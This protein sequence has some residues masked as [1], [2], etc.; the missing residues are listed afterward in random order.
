MWTTLKNLT[1]CLV[2][3]AALVITLT[4]SAAAQESDL[5]AVLR[6]SAPVQEKSA[7]CRQ[8]ARIATPDAVPTLAGLLG[9][10][11]LSH[12][13]RYA[14]EAIDHPSVD[15]ALRDAVGKVQG[16]PRLGVIGSLGVRRDPLA[17]PALAGLLA[18][19]DLDAAQAAARALGNIGTPEAARALERALPAAAGPQQLA[20]CEGWLRCAEALTRD[21]HETS[22]REI[23]DRLRA[24]H[25]APPQVRAAALRGAI[26]IRGTEGAALLADAIRSTDDV[27]A[28]AAMRSAME[29]PGP[30]ITAALVAALPDVAPA[31]QGLLMLALADR[32]EPQVLP[33][34]LEAAQRGDTP[35]RLVAIRA[36]RRVGDASCFPALMDAA[37]QGS[38]DVS[39]AALETLESLQ[40]QAI[41]DQLVAQL[42]DAEGN[43]RMVL[44]ELATRRRSAAAADAF[45]RATEDA[46]PAVRVAA[47]RGLGAVLDAPEVPRLIARLAVN[48]T[49]QEAAALDQALRDIALRASDREQIARQLA[50]ALPTV[51]APVQIRVLE[52]LAAIG[53]NAALETVAAAARSRDDAQRDAAFRVLGQW[54]SIDVAPVLLDLHNATGDERLKTRA[55]RAYIR[56]ARQFDM[57]AD[58]RAEMCRVALKTATRD[59][60]KRLVL[61]ILLRYPS[62]EMQAIALEAAEIPALKDE[63]LLVVMGLA[64]AGINRD[65][66][67][68]ALAQAG[69][70]PVQLEILHAQYGAGE[71][72]KDVTAAL[73]QYAKNY[74]II[75]LP[76]ASYNESLGGDPAP[77]IVKQLKIKYRIDGKEGE[78][79]LSENAMV[80]LPLPQ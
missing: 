25:D 36:L 55:I 3:A 6:S 53:G 61:E 46:A 45:W 54:S 11:R 28:A 35:L 79:V 72:T 24:L 77:G 27:L 17:V 69:Q 20:V 23:Y 51:D 57:P 43:E 60:D 29:V 39:S 33:T 47:W 1:R 42:A 10:E 37:A 44:I 14:L 13:A 4:A 8:L 71:Q 80:V 7:A 34:V 50:D 68:K 12:M 21:G 40:G 66:L 49:D 76:S 70:Q 75:F 67:G 16:A 63:A 74:R 78:V 64:N 9:D 30:E 15:D 22:A 62:P 18:G 73:R 2:R 38:A 65:E 31:R 5:L 56:I 48:Q 52:T 26:V 41:D 58:R 32:R 19:P 59:A